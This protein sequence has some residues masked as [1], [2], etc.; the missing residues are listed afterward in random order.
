MTT[1]IVTDQRFDLHTWHGHVEQASRLHAI[2]RALQASGLM[3][4]LTTLPIR[5]AT[6]AELLAVHSPHM[7]QRVRQ[8]ASYGGGQIDS[9][10]YVTADSWEVGLL[11]AG[12]TIGLV[13]AIA[14]GQCENGFALVRPPGHHATDIRSMGFCLFNNIAIA[15]RVLLDRHNYRRIAIIDFDVHHGNG[16]QDIFY[17]DE[18]V[19]FCSTHASPL[20][21][22]TGA[23]HETGDPRTA[24]GTTLNVPLP[25]GTGDQGYDRI[26]RQIVGPALRRFQPEMILISAGFDAHWSDPIG[27]MALSIKGFA[28]IGQHLLNWADELCQGKIGFVLEGGYSLPALAAGVVTI[29]RL[30][31][32]LDPG[33]DPIGGVDT[34]EPAIDHIINTLRNQHP[35]LMQTGYQGEP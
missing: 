15:A 6:E 21:P 17:R 9:D 25:Y 4:R 13:E 11:A 1:A 5:P 16:T 8:L 23:V 27:P 10:T 14:T 12:A 30:L 19:F 31:L 29:F 32:G 35:L 3:S 34:P 18:R 22:G 7:L 28:R 2:Q 24:P 20:Y 33:P 26:F